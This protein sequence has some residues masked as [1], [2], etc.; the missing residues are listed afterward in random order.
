MK[1]IMVS[2]GFDPLHIGHIRYLQAARVHGNV[3]VALNSDDWLL[4]KK[5]YVFMPFNERKAILEA[6]EA[7]SGV[8]AVDDADG[9]VAKAILQYEPHCFGNGGDRIEPNPDE[10][11]ACQ[12][13]GCEMIF[14]LGGGKIQS[15]SWLVNRRSE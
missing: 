15:S 6:L 7:V 12:L 2:G 3:V 8:C 13:T 10:A 9:T 4:R 14:N 11:L 5:G 1:V